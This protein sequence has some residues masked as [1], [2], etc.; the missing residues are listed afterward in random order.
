MAQLTNDAL[1]EV[2]SED[3]WPMGDEIFI[4][5]GAPVVQAGAQPVRSSCHRVI[6]NGTANG[7]LIMHAIISAEAPSMVWIINDDPTNAIKVFCAVGDT[8]NGAANGSLTI[9]AATSAVFLR[10]P[11]QIKRKG[12][13]SG[14]GTLDWRSSMV[15]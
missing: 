12:G 11:A 14:G 6:K 15:S 2:L 7:A 5:A 4:G 9:T 1:M 8:M 3:G 13:T 10:V